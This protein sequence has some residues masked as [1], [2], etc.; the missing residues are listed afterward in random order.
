MKPL[1][2]GFLLLSIF[3]QFGSTCVAQSNEESAKSSTRVEETLIIE[4]ILA[5]RRELS[6]E[7]EKRFFENA[8]FGIAESAF[9]LSLCY[10]NS[11]TWFVESHRWLVVEAEN[12]LPDA[13][14]NLGLYYQGDDL[15]RAKHWMERALSLGET[16]AKGRIE[17]VNN[18]LSQQD[19]AQVAAIAK[20]LQE[21]LYL[22][23]TEEA[24]LLTKARLGNAESACRI[25]RYYRESKRWTF[26][27]ERWL[28]VA[29]EAGNGE[30]AYHVAKAYEAKY[31]DRS[32]DRIKFWFRKAVELGFDQAKEE[33]KRLEQ[34]K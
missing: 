8:K 24:Q 5:S 32:L 25:G 31:A 27:G 21:S 7:E 12:N 17:R 23:A 4:Q 9:R 29:A 28:V 2:L 30:A 33:L 34:T 18:L 20:E 19:P 10:T 14:S 1:H 15:G 13:V 26:E 16:T 6:P 22:S 3:A 11:R